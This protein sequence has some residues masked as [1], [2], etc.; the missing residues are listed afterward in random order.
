MMASTPQSG[1]PGRVLAAIARR[2]FD[3]HVL[4]AVILP[5]IADLQREV[6]AADSGLG[7]V[8]ARWRG[9]RAFWTLVLLAPV[10]FWWSPARQSGTVAFPD[11]LARLAVT[12]IG[13][14]VL[15]IV[16]PVLGGWMAAVTA[17]GALVALVI[18]AWYARHPLTVPAPAEH[19]PSTPQIN[20]SSTA[21]AGNVGGLIFV[22]GSVFIVAVGVPSLIVFLTAAAVSGGI[23]A[24]ALLRWHASHPMRGL[25]KNPIELR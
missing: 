15:A 3:S 16:G 8:C 13:I 5:T 20:F 6:Q 23:C 25:P 24:W 19:E 17:A 9:Y 11:A 18:H 14:V 22:V 1:P 7:R 4:S 21:V 2:L 10:A 12:S